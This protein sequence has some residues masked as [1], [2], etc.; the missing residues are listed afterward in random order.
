MLRAFAAARREVP[1]LRLLVAGDGELREA[2]T[3]QADALGC[4]EATRFIGWWTRDLEPLYAAIDI[5][6]LTSDNEGTP[7]S[8]IEAMAAGRPVI[9]TDVGGV[10]DLLPD[11]AA[12]VVVGRDDEA[13]FAAAMVRRR[14]EPRA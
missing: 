4:G 2:L 11:P 5:A 7:V 12:G 3:Q 9:A 1:E 14:R 8:L 13:G 10:A 6:A